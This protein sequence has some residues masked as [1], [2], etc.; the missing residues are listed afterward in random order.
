MCIT[1]KTLEIIHND[2]VIPSCFHLMI[3][4]VTKNPQWSGC[5]IKT[6]SNLKMHIIHQ[7]AKCRYTFI[8]MKVPPLND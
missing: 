1:H 2:I 7:L 6:F 3:Q 5:A 8:F 4:S